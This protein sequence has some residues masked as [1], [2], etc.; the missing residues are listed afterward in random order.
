MIPVEKDT[1]VEAAKIKKR[2]KLGLAHSLILATARQVGGR[3]VTGDP[4]M[5]SFRDVIFLAERP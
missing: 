1:A 4:D 2:E 5:K 3:V